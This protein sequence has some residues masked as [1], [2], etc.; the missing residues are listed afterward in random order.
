MRHESLR[1]SEKFL[2]NDHTLP[3][4][5]DNVSRAAGE[6]PRFPREESLT[7]SDSYLVP[8]A[9]Y[10]TQHSALILSRRRLPRVLQNPLHVGNRGDVL[11]PH[12][13]IFA[14]GH[15]AGEPAYDRT[16]LVQ[17]PLLHLGRAVDLRQ[18]AL[19]GIDAAIELVD[20]RLAIHERM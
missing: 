14:V 3:M 17:L 13:D 9:S 1:I 8:H 5:S 12:A 10:P 4:T 2:R 19:H 15:A 18:I 7:R 6:E 16:G 11:Q 20:D